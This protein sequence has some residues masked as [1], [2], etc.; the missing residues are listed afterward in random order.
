VTSDTLLKLASCTKLITSIAALQ[1]VERGLIDLDEPVSRILPEL[2]HSKVISWDD[3]AAGTVTVTEAKTAITL[4]HLLTHSSGLSY[5]PWNPLL[6]AWRKSTGQEPVMMAMGDPAAALQIPLVFEPG[7]GWSYGVS[8]DWTGVLVNRL[9]KIT[10]GEY[11]VENIF[12]V[13]GRTAPFP[14][15]NLKR[16]TE[17]WEQRMGGGLRNSSGGLDVE[18]LVGFEEN[19]GEYGGHG[20]SGTSEDFFAVIQDLASPS[21]KLLGPEIMVALFTPQFVPG[22][23]AHAFLAASAPFFDVFVRGANT[24]S[25]I[26]A[27]LGGLIIVDDLPEYGQPAGTLTWA[28]LANTMWFVNRQKG[29]AGWFATQIMPFTDPLTMDAYNLFRKDLWETFNKA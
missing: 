5:E 1:C 26:N 22:S 3:E 10:L 20:L 28:G 17:L 23:A 2:A 13:V 25:D 29:V 6:Q 12:K 27:G 19:G 9:S 18:A 11:F 16:H 15:F 8:L 14:V 24:K 7:Q 21:P 4:R